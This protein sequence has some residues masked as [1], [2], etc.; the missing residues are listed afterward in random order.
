MVA[1]KKI[2]CTKCDRDAVIIEEKIYYCGPCAVNKFV[3]VHE[4]FR[5]KPNNNSGKN[6]VKGI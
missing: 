6:T 2:K 3:R 1:I 5:Y 4:R